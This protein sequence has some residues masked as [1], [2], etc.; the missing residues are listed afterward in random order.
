MEVLQCG[1]I[2]YYAGK[3]LEERNASGKGIV[4]RL[5]DIDRGR[6]LITHLKIDSVAVTGRGCLIGVYRGMLCSG[7]EIIHDK[8]EQVVR[9]NIA[10]SG[11]KQHGE[12]SVFL[13][14]FVQRWNQMLF[15]D[16][17]FI[18]ELLHQ[19]VF[20]FGYDLTSFS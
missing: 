3:H 16:G 15:G 9:T 6:G 19:L 2:L 12:N 11:G 13:N 7:G 8:I 14:S 10:Q 18:K 20:A 4:G 5:E 1:V 17:A